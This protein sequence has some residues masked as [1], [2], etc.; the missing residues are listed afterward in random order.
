MDSGRKQQQLSGTAV[1]PHGSPHKA[2]G[3]TRHPG[4]YT[5]A[6]RR[7]SMAGGR[8][9]GQSGGKRRR[10]QLQPPLR[11]TMMF[12]RLRLLFTR[13]LGSRGTCGAH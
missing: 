8:W 13:Y 5:A 2:A 7:R 3:V 4:S 6:H 12:M 11:W 9:T 1:A 10:A